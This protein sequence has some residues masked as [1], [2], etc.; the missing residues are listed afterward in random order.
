MD[1]VSAAQL[2]LC[3][4]FRQTGSDSRFLKLHAIVFGNRDGV[5]GSNGEKEFPTRGAWKG[6]GGGQEVRGTT[7]DS[8]FCGVEQELAIHDFFRPQFRGVE[9]AETRMQ[10]H[11][12]LPTGLGLGA[13]GAVPVVA[14]PVGWG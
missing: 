7:Q 4:L 1:F 6:L 13:L 11:G 3:A 12:G 14:R 8:G 5:F 9:N 10:M 2:A